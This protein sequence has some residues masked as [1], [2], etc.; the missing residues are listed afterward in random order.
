MKS[1]IAILLVLLIASSSCK[2]EG[3]LR[4]QSYNIVAQNSSGLT[5]T[6]T[7]KEL[8]DA[9]QTQVDIQLQHTIWN[10][11]YIC[12]IHDG[13]PTGYHIAS[14][15][16]ESYAVGNNFSYQKNIVLSYDSAIHYDGTFVVHDSTG[17]QLLAKC[18]I[19]KNG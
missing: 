16:F 17:I 6:V 19:G 9:T 14:F 13:P 11:R 12:H 8:T 18:G 2:K 15:G 1:I 10:S 5:G 4:T 3:V 7:F